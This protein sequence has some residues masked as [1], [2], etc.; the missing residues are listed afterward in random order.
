MRARGQTDREAQSRG[1][2]E[3]GGGVNIKG[4]GVKRGRHKVELENFFFLPP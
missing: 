3:R 1:E 4:G 2:Q